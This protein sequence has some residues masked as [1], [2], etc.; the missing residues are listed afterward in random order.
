MGESEWSAWVAIK[1]DKIPSRMSY[2]LGCCVFLCDCGVWSPW[3]TLASL[4]LSGGGWVLSTGV[5]ESQKL[6]ERCQNNNNHNPTTCLEIVPPAYG[7]PTLPPK[8]EKQELVLVQGKELCPR[9]AVRQ[10]G[11]AVADPWMGLEEAAVALVSSSGL[12]FSQGWNG[13]SPGE[14]LPVPLREPRQECKRGQEAE[15]PRA[16]GGSL[17][18]RP[19]GKRPAPGEGLRSGKAGRGGAGA[20]GVGSMAGRGRASGHRGTHL[21]QEGPGPAGRRRQQPPPHGAHDALSAPSSALWP[22]APR[23]AL[24]PA[25]AAGR[26]DRR[27]RGAE[28]AGEQWRSPMA[29][30]EPG[31]WRL[32][33]RRHRAR[34][35]RR[36]RGWPRRQWRLLAAGL[37]CCT[38]LALYAASSL[39]DL[40]LLRWREDDDEEPATTVLLWWEPFGRSRRLGDC[41]LRFNIS[42]CTLTANRSRQLEAQAVLFHHRDLILQGAG[43]LP[44]ARPAGQ[45][46]V[47]MNFESPSHSAGLRSLAGLFNWT[48]SYRVDSDVFVPYGYLQP[49]P[50]PA[51]YTLPGK[52]K[53]VAWVISNWNEEHARVRYYHQLKKYLPIDVYGAQGL[54]LKED[55]VVATVSQYKFYLAFEN[56]QHPDYITEKLWRN[57]FKSWAVPV[58]LGPP[59]SNYE[60]FVPSDSF[61]HVED[62]SDPMQL[63]GYLKF[64]DKNKSRYR[65]YFAWRKRYDVQVTSFWDEHCCRVC[66]AVRTAGQQRKTIQNLASWFES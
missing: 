42:A 41:R 37:T 12:L 65:R 18:G 55:S 32:R 48:M 3:H 7:T 36:W 45:R 54:E 39:Q 56:S 50:G 13:A 10:R 66:K 15:P 59:R 1:E 29:R 35:P 38:V 19:C 24:S 6:N 21:G 62:F 46:W 26:G 61:I 27:R 60:L 5:D 16:P 2:V 40:P 43:D 8:E 23:A 22:A 34:W 17:W 44:Q 57:A 31:S 33:G 30:P 47:W 4:Y 63:A 28:A 58:V 11:Q 14:C 25:A 64:L 53:L 51:P 20:L 9:T 52:S 49:R